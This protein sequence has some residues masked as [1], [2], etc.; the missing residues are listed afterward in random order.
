VHRF[1]VDGSAKSWKNLVSGLSRNIAG[2]NVLQ[3][4]KQKAKIES[5]VGDEKDPCESES[6]LQVCSTKKS[7]YIAMELGWN[8]SRCMLVMLMG[9]ILWRV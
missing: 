6:D 8:G 2:Y 1:N 9:R 4:E 7:R 3:E 5:L